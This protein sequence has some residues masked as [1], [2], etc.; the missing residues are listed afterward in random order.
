[1]QV[2]SESRETVRQFF[3]ATMGQP[4]ELNAGGVLVANMMNFD[5]D[6]SKLELQRDSEREISDAIRLIT[7]SNR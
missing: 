4:I 7:G 5:P 6:P 1:M 2:D 3:E